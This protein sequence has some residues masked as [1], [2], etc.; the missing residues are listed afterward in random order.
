V[1]NRL[2]ELTFVEYIND[3]LHG[4]VRITER[5]QEVIHTRIFQRL[6]RIKQ[7]GTANFVYP[8]ANHSRFEH[9]IGTMHVTS[10][11]LD[12]LQNRFGLECDKSQK[13]T[14]RIAA[15]LHDIGHGPFS[16]TFEELLNRNEKYVY[17]FNGKEL[18]NHEDFN[19]YTL[20][21]NLE[22]KK[23]LGSDRHQIVDFLFNDKPIGII[24]S[25]LLIGDIGSDRIDYLLR[26]T[27]YTGLGHRPDINSLISHMRLSVKE[28][29]HPRLALEAEG[30]LA[31]ELLITTRYYHY[32]MIVHNPKTRSVELLF[33]R[34]ME[35]FLKRKVADP[36]AYLFKAFTEYDDSIILH[37]LFKFKGSLR[38]LFYS[39]KGFQ[40]IYS[41]GLRQLRSGVTKYCLYRFFFDRKGLMTYVRQ[42]GR[43]LKKAID[44]DNILFDIHLFKHDV[45]DI[46]F[47][48][49]RYETEKEW[50]SSLLIDQSNILRLIPS[51]QLLR[52][53]IC[54][55]SKQDLNEEEAKELF[56]KI[57]RNRRIFLRGDILVSIAKK[58]MITNGFQL[59]DEFY[60]FLCALRDFYK[61][62]PWKNRS[63]DLPKEEVFRGIS[64]FYDLVNK[65]SEK[66]GKPKLGFQKFFKE[67]SNGFQYSTKGFSILNAL[68]SMSILRLDYTPVKGKSKSKPFHFTYIV[69]PVEKDIRK[70]VYEGLPDFDELRPQFIEVFRELDWSEY[71]ADFFPL[72]TKGE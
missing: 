69:R 23:V 14:I 70:R 63:S 30:T 15:L 3:P 40:P 42:V 8:G 29:T 12:R 2:P 67:K 65:C 44:F 68:A 6:K 7:L 55:M 16:H 66:I 35:N 22:L 39:G 60:T 32:S 28:K 48:A 56:G 17:S 51:E 21:N 53:F 19:E 9:S 46:I 57:E 38:H 10:L 45:P 47:Y 36:K 52:S 41:M 61:E 33:L 1:V 72:K 5:E 34:L 20:R 27:Y 25:E 71:F 31:A 64:R 50:I 59:I 43:K 62:K 58:S 37:D 49:D 11:I 13:Q 18:R 4:P 26:D 54:V 24:P